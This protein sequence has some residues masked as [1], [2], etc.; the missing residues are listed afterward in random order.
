MAATEAVG[1]AVSA[2]AV[3]ERVLLLL[4][5]VVV[6]VVIACCWN[7]NYREIFLWCELCRR[8]LYIGSCISCSSRDVHIV[9]FLQGRNKGRLGEAMRQCRW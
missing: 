9:G 6:V 2:G 3:G 5:V 1:T 4:V 7:W 8:G